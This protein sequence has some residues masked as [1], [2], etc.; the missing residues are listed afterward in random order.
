MESVIFSRF[1]LEATTRFEL[2]SP[3][4]NRVERGVLETLI[5]VAPNLHQTERRDLSSPNVRKVSK[6]KEECTLSKGYLVYRLSTTRK[7]EIKAVKGSAKQI[8]F[9]PLPL[10]VVSDIFPIIEKG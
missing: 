9:T 2:K 4:K 6:I 3:Q 7:F 8:H 10:F 1:Y 5:L